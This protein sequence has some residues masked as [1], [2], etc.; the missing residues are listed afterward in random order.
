MAAKASCCSL[1]G[2]S[3]VHCSEAEQVL[4][5]CASH[6]L[7]G[8]GHRNLRVLP[9]VCPSHRTLSAVWSA[10]SALQS[11]I[12][13]PFRVLAASM[14][15]P[16]ANRLLRR[17]CSLAGQATLQGSEP[18]CAINLDNL[19]ACLSSA[20]HHDALLGSFMTKCRVFENCRH[21]RK[22]EPDGNLRTPLRVFMQLNFVKLRIIISN[23]CSVM[24]VH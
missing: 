15:G 4:L 17:S 20:H 18:T 8:R 16:G 19:G 9:I 13:G 21:L 14:H 11:A 5:A 10:I 7:C 6:C 22:H 24:S 1:R 23:L 3:S 2:S 12:R